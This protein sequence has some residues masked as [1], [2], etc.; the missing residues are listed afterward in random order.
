[1]LF[2]L[3]R[4]FVRVKENGLGS[5][6]VDLTR[7]LLYILLPLSL[8]LSICLIGGG[9]AQNLIPA[10]QVP[11][12]ETLAVDGSGNIIKNAKIDTETDT[13][14]LDGN[15]VADARIVKEQL[16]PEGPAASQ[17]AIKQLGTN[18]GGFFGT[19]SA[20]PLENP[21]GFTNLVELLSILL[22]PAALCFTFGRNIKDKRQG[23]AIFCAMLDGILK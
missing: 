20:N 23:R 13:V 5:F 4:G 12:V 15:V 19:N 1:M 16:V 7:V 14:T 6:W 22:I 21:N 11:L 3:I 18:G 9:V 10:D 8:L 2:A 17:I